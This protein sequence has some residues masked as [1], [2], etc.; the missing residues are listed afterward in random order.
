MNVLIMLQEILLI[1]SK[2]ILEEYDRIVH[3]DEIVEKEAY[4]F[5]SIAAVKKILQLSVF[6][7][8]K[9]TI[10]AVKDDPDDDKFIEAAVEGSVT[11]IISQDNHLLKLK[12]FRG[13]RI[14]TPEDFLRM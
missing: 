7:D 11:Y 4:R 3:S 8:P 5:E 2:P 6:V 13:I 10:K 1:I 12:E 14:L 9:E